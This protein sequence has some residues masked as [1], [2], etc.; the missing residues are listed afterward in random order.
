MDILHAVKI[1]T[2]F[3]KTVSDVF[4]LTPLIK[5]SFLFKNDSVDPEK[6]VLSFWDITKHFWRSIQK[7]KDIV[8]EENWKDVPMSYFHVIF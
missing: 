5:E 2:M 8:Q 1:E 3:T 7:S 6:I 4:F